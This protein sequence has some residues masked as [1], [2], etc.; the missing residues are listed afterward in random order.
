MGTGKINLF[1][2]ILFF[3]EIKLSNFDLLP[4][5]FFFFVGLFIKLGLAPF[6][7]W[8]PQIYDGAP[9]LITLI[10]LI[11]PKFVLF[12][13]FIKLY[14]FVFKFLTG[15]FFSNFFIERFSILFFWFFR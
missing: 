10:L 8:V 5:L 11:L 3:Y 7:F 4:G 6:H 9:N 15:F 2:L 13:L 14:F 12:L 1:D